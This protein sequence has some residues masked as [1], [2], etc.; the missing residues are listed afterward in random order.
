MSEQTKTISLVMRIPA[1]RISLDVMKEACQIAEE[2]NLEIYLTT[3]QNLR[4]NNV[5]EH[6]VESIKAKIIPYGITFKA[7]G[8]FPLPRVCVGAPHCKMAKID[9]ARLSEKIMRHFA[10]RS[11]I[12][13]K[14]KIAIGACTL[15]CSGSR[16]T[17][18]AIEATGTGLNVYAGGK[19]G[20]AP[21]AG[22]RIK[23]DITETEAIQVIETLF[24]F[25][26]KKTSTRQR[27]YKLLNDPEFPYKKV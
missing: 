20:V 15:G 24:D 17:D 25:H 26:Q 27:L 4:L 19:D 9:T 22:I 14:L 13:E 18:I 8:L 7:K 16:S 12:K 11:G 21:R 23:K 10:D 1:G 2:Y 5:P 6:A 3:Q